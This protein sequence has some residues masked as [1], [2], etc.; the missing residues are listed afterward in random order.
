MKGSENMSYKLILANGTELENLEMNG[1]TLISETEVLAEMFSDENMKTVTLVETD[2]QG[3]EHETVFR[4]AQTNGVFHEEDGYHFVIWGAGPTEIAL[5]ELR[6]DFGTA[7]N[8][9]LDFVIGGE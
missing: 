6:E 9:L 2:E 8:E 1:N 7:I 3:N 5:H 4:Y